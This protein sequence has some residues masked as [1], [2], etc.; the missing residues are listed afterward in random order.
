MTPEQATVGRAVVYRAHPE[1]RPE[2]GVIKSVHAVGQGIAHVL[3]D[4]DGTAKATRLADL[5]LVGVIRRHVFDGERCIHCGVNVYDCEHEND[6]CCNERDPMVYTTE[7]D[8][9]PACA[10]CGSTGVLVERRGN[11]VCEWCAHR[12]W[13]MTPDERR[14]TGA[15]VGEE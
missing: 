1:A 12:Y 6:E 10:D 11:M 3:Y 9:T 2:D 4:G 14:E 7:T 8:S 5:E 15:R 13:P